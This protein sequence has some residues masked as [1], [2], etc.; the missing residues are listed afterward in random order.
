MPWEYHEN[1]I[2]SDQ[3]II[4]W[5]NSPLCN[6]VNVLVKSNESLKAVYWGSLQPGQG[7]AQGMRSGDLN[8]ISNFPELSYQYLTFSSAYGCDK[9]PPPPPQQKGSVSEHEH[10]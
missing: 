4:K 10:A 9:L 6:I 3:G 2:I 1:N 8:Y 5:S 7:T